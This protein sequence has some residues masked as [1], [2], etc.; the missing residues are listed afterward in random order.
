[1][2]I[3][4]KE[5]EELAKKIATIQNKAIEKTVDKKIK[6]HLK[7]CGDIYTKEEM[8]ELMPIWRNQL[9]RDVADTL[10]KKIDL[11]KVDMKKFLESLSNK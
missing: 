1:M 11:N 9:Y 5:I 7:D 2:I 6:K 8:D 3:N 10:L 4:K